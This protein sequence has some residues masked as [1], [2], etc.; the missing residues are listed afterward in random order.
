MESGTLRSTS[1]GGARRG[2]RGGRGYEEDEDDDD[3]DG[4]KIFTNPFLFFVLLEL[5]LN[6]PRPGFFPVPF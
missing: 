3:D 1:G 2:G 4:E 5:I 6:P